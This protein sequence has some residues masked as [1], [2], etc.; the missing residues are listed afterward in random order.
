MAVEGITTDRGVKTADIHITG[1]EKQ[2]KI[3]EIVKAT[4]IKEA[5]ET[6][7]TAESERI[8]WCKEATEAE[9][10]QTDGSTNLPIEIKE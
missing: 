4:E 1:K 8:A 2:Q 6:E 10:E 3:A 5:A 7:K 9:K